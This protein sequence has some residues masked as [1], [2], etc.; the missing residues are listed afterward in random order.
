M[1]TQLYETDFYGWTQEQAAKLRALLRE[2]SNLDL[3]IENIAE[4]IESLG[5]SDYRQLVSRFD[6][7]CIHLLKLHF[8]T[9]LEC[10]RLWKNSVRGQRRRIAKLLRESPSLKPRLNAALEEGYQDALRH[11]SDEKLIELV[12]PDHLPGTSPFDVEDCLG[13][14]RWPEMRGRN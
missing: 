10:E 7:I 1:A 6:E 14:E 4:E 9:I 5:R 13:E 12:M 3:D 8:S 11:F 2:R